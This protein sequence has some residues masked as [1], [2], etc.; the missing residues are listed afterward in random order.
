MI[1]LGDSYDQV[2]N[3]IEEFLFYFLI[4][5][6]ISVFFAIII[7][8]M[9]SG[10]IVKPIKQ[11]TASSRLIAG[12]NFKSKIHVNSKD[13]IE[14]LS[15][16]FNDMAS[17]LE[18]IIFKI[19][20]KNV[21]MNSILS[22]IQEGILALDLHNKV[23]LLN[24][25]VNRILDNEVNVVKGQYI[26]E[27]LQNIQEIYEIKEKISRKEDYYGE[28]KLESKKIISLYTYPII[29]NIER[30]GTL[31]VIR[32]ITALRNLEKMRKDFVA[33]VSHELRTPLTSIAGFVE[34]L[35]T[36][37]LDVENKNKA[38][39][40]I[41][42]ET[43]KLKKMIN[44]LLKLSKIESIEKTE[45]VSIFDLKKEISEILILL[46]PQ[47]MKKNIDIKLDISD[48]ISS[49]KGHRE[50]FRLIF[51][52][53][54]ENAIKYN[55]EKGEVNIFVCNFENGIKLIVEDNG[56]GISEENL[57]WIF[58]RFY[59]VKNKD[60]NTPK[61]TGLGLSIVEETINYLGGTIK[62]TSKL[63]QGTRVEIIVP[64]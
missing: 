2:D 45:S 57:P 4:A 24:E 43:E 53:L 58:G 60:T 22:S 44:E 15:N 1:R 31:I 56:I 37:E 6:V 54:I 13:E 10:K 42:M 29:D 50:L 9:T 36:K 41:E 27:I 3:I 11:L 52:N 59:R 63:E 30:I 51:M 48:D 33:N 12:G 17:E 23:F 5:N 61:G 40:I 32:D 20:S 38:L 19:K 39:D 62:I 21:Q 26:D 14:E 47:I 7:A 18:A 25:S 34:T 46:E 35:K 8:Y 16:T 28:I 49:I 55:K 64:E